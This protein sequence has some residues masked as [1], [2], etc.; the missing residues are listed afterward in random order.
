MPKINEK[1]A[2][3]F[4]EKFVGMMMEL[5][6]ATAFTILPLSLAALWSNGN[7]FSTTTEA[8]DSWRA[9]SVVVENEIRQHFGRIRYAGPDKTND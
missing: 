1:Q 2:I 4:S 7:N 9:F 8:V 6:R 5:D 3:E